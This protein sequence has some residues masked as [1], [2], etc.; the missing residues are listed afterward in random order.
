MTSTSGT[1]RAMFHPAVQR[2]F[3][4]TLGT[5]TAAQ[6]DGWASIAAGR[7]TL[8]AAPTGSGKT[9]AAFLTA[10]DDLF[11][12][13][14]ERPLPDEVRVLYVSPL[15]AL[16]A[17]IHKNL[18]EPRNGIRQLAEDAGFGGPQITAAVRTGDTSQAERAA[19][20]R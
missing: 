10:L 9:L 3:A 13:G 15:K 8:I 17:D 19:M 20:I 6:R 18:A 4:E 14:L 1:I 7:H 16:S 5:P 2:W 12:E 11:R